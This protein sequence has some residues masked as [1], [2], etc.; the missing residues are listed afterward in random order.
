MNVRTDQPVDKSAFGLVADPGTLITNLRFVRTIYPAG[1]GS[2]LDKKPDER[3]LSVL[4]VPGFTSFTYP[5]GKT[6][7][8]YNCLTLVC[9]PACLLD[10]GLSLID[11]IHIESHERLKYAFMYAT[12]SGYPGHYM[13]AYFEK[14]AVDAFLSKTPD[15]KRE[16]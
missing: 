3:F 1:G 5:K 7:S 8:L 12:Y 16:S 15:V 2:A 6:P 13:L 4:Y 9:T 10:D 14:G 11:A